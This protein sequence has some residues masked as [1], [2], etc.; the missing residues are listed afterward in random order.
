[1]SASE[2]GSFIEAYLS[3]NNILKAGMAFPVLTLHNFQN[4]F[5]PYRNPTLFCKNRRMCCSAPSHCIGFPLLT[6]TTVVLY[7]CDATL[8]FF[9]LCAGVV[10]IHTKRYFGSILCYIMGNLMWKAL[11]HTFLCMLSC[12]ARN[13]N[14]LSAQSQFLSLSC[15]YY[16]SVFF[17]CMLFICKQKEKGRIF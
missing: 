8:A 17:K 13:I 10:M 14:Q 6:I 15:S 9:S 2:D 4:T 11:T 12:E 7:H 1:M 16:L 5:F 3:D